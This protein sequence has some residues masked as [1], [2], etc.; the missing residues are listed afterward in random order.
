MMKHYDMYFYF[1]MF[2]YCHEMNLINYKYNLL[3]DLDH[4]FI[5]DALRMNYLFY[6]L[7][8]N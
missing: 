4:N 1:W 8:S 6:D 5:Y 2:F 3:I 7:N